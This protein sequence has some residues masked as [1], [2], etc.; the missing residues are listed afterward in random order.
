MR[1]RPATRPASKRPWSGPWTCYGGDL[2]PS[3]YDDWLLPE[4]ERLLQAYLRALERLIELLEEPAGLRRGHPATPGACC[5]T[6]RCTRP[7]TGA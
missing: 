7:A 2:L 4:R 6:T 3:C 5:A 1:R